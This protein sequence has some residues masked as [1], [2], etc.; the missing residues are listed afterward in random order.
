MKKNLILAFGLLAFGCLDAQSP[1]AWSFSAKKTA[2]KTYEIHCRVEVNP[3][4]HTYSQFTP[5]GGP[6]PTKFE[7]S[8][9]PLYSLEGKVKE[10]GKMITRHEEVFGVDVKYFDG[11]VDFV[12]TIKLRT[13]AKTNVSGSVEF[14][15]CN[16][17][18]CL[19]PTT[20]KFTI[21]LN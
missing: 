6:L 2:E 9:N 3:P 11:K 14:M 16:D 1:Y 4:W 20:R 17:E 8:K 19:P 12:Q 21:A 15:V 13:N 10:N 18:Q 7:F 5:D